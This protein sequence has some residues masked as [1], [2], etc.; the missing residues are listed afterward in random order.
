MSG[1]PNWYYDH[2][3]ACTCSECLSPPTRSRK[4][5][6][7]ILVGVG[8]AVLATFAFWRYRKKKS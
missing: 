5:I 1:R 8:I 6:W 4:N 7:K 2:P 3:P